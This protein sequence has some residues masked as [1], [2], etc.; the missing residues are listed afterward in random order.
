MLTTQTAVAI[1]PFPG[2]MES[3]R[4]PVG[5]LSDSWDS[6]VHQKIGEFP[7]VRLTFTAYSEV[8]GCFRVC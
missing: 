2:E 6:H 1:E 4:P 5:Q 7:M 8:S 3:S